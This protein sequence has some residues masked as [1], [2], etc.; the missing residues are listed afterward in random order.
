MKIIKSTLASFVLLVILI[1]AFSTVLNAD[2]EEPKQV[3]FIKFVSMFLIPE[4]AQ[5][6]VQD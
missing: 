5:W 3:D 2:A 1:F 6:N 4:T